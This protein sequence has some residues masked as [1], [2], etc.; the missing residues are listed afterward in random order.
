[1]N[2]M[3]CYHVSIFIEMS[4]HSALSTCTATIYV[5]EERNIWLMHWKSIQWDQSYHR[6]LFHDLYPFAQ[7]LNTLKLFGNQIDT[8]GG[9]YLAES[10]MSNRVRWMICSVIFSSSLSFPSGAHQPPPWVER[11]TCWRSEILIW[12]AQ[13][14]SS[15]M[16]ETL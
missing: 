5:L 16:N 10:L 13:S 6:I 3:L 12:C 14:Q 15:E 7:T 1:M 4:R 2:T 9:K 8:A 11:Y